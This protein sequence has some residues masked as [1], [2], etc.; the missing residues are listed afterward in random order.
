MCVGVQV[1]RRVG[2]GVQLYRS[3]AWAVQ[4]DLKVAQSPSSLSKAALRTP[5]ALAIQRMSRG[6]CS[7][8]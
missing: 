5:H 1:W 8:Q 2:V 3:S 7:E 6:S 4:N